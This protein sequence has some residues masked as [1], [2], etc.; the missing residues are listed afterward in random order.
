M[1]RSLLIISF[2]PLIQRLKGYIEEQYQKTVSLLELPYRLFDNTP[3]YK[4]DVYYYYFQ[5]ISRCLDSFSPTF[6]RNL[7]VFFTIRIDY[8]NFERWNPLLHFEES[9]ARSHPPEILLSWL[10]LSYPEVQW[11]FLGQRGENSTESVDMF[12][13]MS[14]YLDVSNIFVHPAYVPMFDPSGL[15]NEIKKTLTNP[16]DW[17]ER[18]IVNGIPQRSKTAIAID[19]ETSYAYLNAYTAYRFGYRGWAITAWEMMCNVLGAKN[20]KIDLVFE[21]LYL[22]FSDSTSSFNQARNYGK[23]R[24]YFSYQQ[25]RLSNLEFRDCLFPL[26]KDVQRRIIITVGHRRTTKEKKKWDDNQEYLE[27]F[28]S[29]WKKILLK[30]LSGIFDLWK[31]ARLFPVQNCVDDSDSWNKKL[32]GVLRFNFLKNRKE[33]PVFA[34]GFIW[35]PVHEPDPE[36]KGSHSAPGRLLE[37]AE[38]LIER[39]EKILTDVKNIPDAIQAAVLALEAKE[40]LADRT[41][42]T[43]LQALSVQH[44]A[45]ILAESMFHGG[46]F[47][48]NVKDRFKEIQKE[49]QAISRWFNPER[50][51]FS[52][53]N[54]QLTLIEDLAKKFRHLNQFYEEQECLEVAR[55]LRFAVWIR[56]NPIRWLWWPL[57]KYIDI[58]L[59]SPRYILSVV[60]IWI[61]LFTPVYF[62]SNPQ[63]AEGIL[64]AFAAAIAFFFTL[65]PAEGWS[66][67]TI[68]GTKYWWNLIIA[69]QGVVSFV[70][71][72]L[73]LAHIYMI[74]SRK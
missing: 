69:F 21:D 44:Q 66:G 68:F 25:E 7:V 51:K 62:F 6:L 32:S 72:G 40:L 20:E 10:I 35:P 27:T 65:Q 11:I 64:G 33:F 18:R 34:E 60:F 8:H 58:I 28:D 53:L 54:T 74:I 5:K 23:C 42:E 48:L 46:K 57:L 13:L 31:K 38:R 14:D 71:L 19:E 50:R 70:N 63:Q 37:I 39:A 12:H 15:R 26:L 4:I 2:E 24:Q 36:K 55:K 61:I 73:F 43:A 47:D 56:K 3:V 52:E 41:P 16:I 30:P 9:R 1:N 22:N 59:R 29:T 49:V 17:E 67:I 45:E